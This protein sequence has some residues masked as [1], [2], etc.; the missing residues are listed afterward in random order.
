MIPLNADTATEVNHTNV[1]ESTS[2]TADK[3]ATPKKHTTRS[4]MVEPQKGGK[5]H[6]LEHHDGHR[7]KTMNR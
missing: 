1:P 7:R 2:W 6:Q 4:R 3:T 5:E